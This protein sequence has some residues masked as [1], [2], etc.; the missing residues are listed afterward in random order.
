MQA[1]NQRGEVFLTGGNAV[2][3]DD[4]RAAFFQ[5]VLHGARQAFAV[6]LFVMNNGNAL[7]LNGLEDVFGGG[8]ALRGVQTGGTHNVLVAALGQFRVRCAWGDHQYAF[9]FVD[10]RR[11]LRGG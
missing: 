2:E 6:L 3:E 9:V 11:R 1:G 8:G 7:W 4:V 10:I 5:A